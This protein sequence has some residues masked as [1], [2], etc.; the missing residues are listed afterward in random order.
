MQ[1]SVCAIKGTNHRIRPEVPFLN[2]TFEGFCIDSEALADACTRHSL[3]F[4]CSFHQW[5][6]DALLQFLKGICLLIPFEEGHQGWFAGL[7]VQLADLSNSPIY[8]T[9][10]Q[11]SYHMDKK[12]KIAKADAWY[13]VVDSPSEKKVVI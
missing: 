1:I 4:R 10:R 12:S 8:L 7:P 6:Y 2:E 11:L 13:P 3:E 5:S 9:I